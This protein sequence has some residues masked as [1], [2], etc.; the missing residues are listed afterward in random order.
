M[1]SEDDLSANRDQ[2]KQPLPDDFPSVE[3]AVEFWETHSLADYWDDTQEVAITVRA[4]ERQWVPLAA[5][6]AQQT[7]ERARQDGVGEVWNGTR[8]TRRCPEPVE[9]IE[10][11]YANLIRVHPRHPRCHFYRCIELDFP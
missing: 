11:I 10:R 3:A 6:L 9:G 5:H 7:A 4:T 2:S 8:L 1:R